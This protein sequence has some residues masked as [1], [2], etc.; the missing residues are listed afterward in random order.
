[1]MRASRAPV[2]ILQSGVCTSMVLNLDI[3]Y[4]LEIK[5]DVTLHAGQKHILAACSTVH[6]AGYTTPVVLY[7]FINGF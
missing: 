6:Y 3:R 1:M 2:N 7:S 5:S 4:A